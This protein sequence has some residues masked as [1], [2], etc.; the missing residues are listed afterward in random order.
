LNK[1]KATRVVNSA[2]EGF[3]M[4]AGISRIGFI[5]IEGLKSKFQS[6]DF[7]DLLKVTDVVG[8]AES[9]ARLEKYEIVDTKVLIKVGARQ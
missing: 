6:R 7:F 2:T 3:D 4:A 1:R 9:W 5:N 8:I